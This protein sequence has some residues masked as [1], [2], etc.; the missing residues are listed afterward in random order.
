M[1]GVRKWTPWTERMYQEF[2]DRNEDGIMIIEVTFS[3]DM[4]KLMN[5]SMPLSSYQA[6]PK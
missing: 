4:G 3:D 2:S 6:L 5:E 1:R